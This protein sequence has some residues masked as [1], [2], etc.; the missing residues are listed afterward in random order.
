M[1]VFCFLYLFSFVCLCFFFGGGGEG[2]KGVVFIFSLEALVCF[3]ELTWKGKVTTMP[4]TNKAVAI[5]RDGAVL[6]PYFFRFLKGRLS[7]KLG[8]VF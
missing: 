3:F 2:V 7:N 1:C 4:A 6:S 8:S 5:F